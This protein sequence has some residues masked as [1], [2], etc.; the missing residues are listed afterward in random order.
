M[1]ISPINLHLFTTL[2]MYKVCSY[3]V[4]FISKIFF[5]SD[6]L[7]GMGGVGGQDFL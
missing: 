3:A 7:E 2:P 5:I 6:K 4:Y 1:K